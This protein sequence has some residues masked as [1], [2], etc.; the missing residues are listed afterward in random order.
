MIENLSAIFAIW[1]YLYSKISPT[2]VEIFSAILAIWE[3]WY[4]KTSAIPTII[5]AVIRQKYIF[6]V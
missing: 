5:G 2:V 1:E 6:A 4:L 3:Y